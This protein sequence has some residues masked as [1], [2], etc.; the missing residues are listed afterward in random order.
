M[1]EN[2]R[3]PTQTEGEGSGPRV[4]RLGPHLAEA[5]SRR[6]ASAGRRAKS[7]PRAA[8]EPGG[9]APRGPIPEPLR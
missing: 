6:N 8:I 1:F 2:R 4:K 7:G 3:S 5:K 9:G